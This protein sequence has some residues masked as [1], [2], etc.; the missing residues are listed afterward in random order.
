MRRPLPSPALVLVRARALWFALALVGACNSN[1]AP[2]RA[3]P[4][5]TTPTPT[6][7]TPTAPPPPRAWHPHCVDDATALVASGGRAA[8]CA[9]ADCARY[10]EGD[11]PVHIDRP[12]PAPP[13]NEASVR[14]DGGHLATCNPSG[15]VALGPRLV[16][17]IADA[18]DSRAH[19]RPGEQPRGEV[20]LDTTT[21]RAAVILFH[22]GSR[23]WNVADDRIVEPQPPGQ[24][25]HH[26]GVRAI[27]EQVVGARVLVSWWL[28]D[29]GACADP[30]AISS[31][32]VDA[33][34]AALSDELP[35]LF[36][37]VVRVAL[38]RFVV[39]ADHPGA[40]LSGATATG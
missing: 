23:M 29:N 2:D 28:C 32:L 10:D 25:A 17:A 6:A 1:R 36:S 20:S 27:G 15:C 4:V 31:S 40:L 7:P 12:P 26:P 39:A 33:R 18:R 37:Q 38:D 24:L 35:G 22:G 13:V 11:A 14:D 3:V 5:V 34:G 16:A 8:L 19:E 30:D 9:G 21:D